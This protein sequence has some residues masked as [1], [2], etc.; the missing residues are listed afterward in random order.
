MAQLFVE[1]S[2]VEVQRSGHS[3]LFSQH[4]TRNG[5]R[6]R[7]GYRQRNFHYCKVDNDL[8]R[9]SGVFK[10][11]LLHVANSETCWMILTQRKTTVATYWQLPRRVVALQRRLWRRFRVV[12][13]YSLTILEKAKVLSKI[14]STVLYCK[15]LPTVDVCVSICLCFFNLFRAGSFAG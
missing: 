13:P 3:T 14:E 11:L 12:P 7:I 4:C 1:R 2:K 5:C 10:F 6:Q 8:S 9:K 15:Y